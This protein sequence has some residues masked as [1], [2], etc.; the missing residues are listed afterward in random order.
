MHLIHES[1]RG[2]FASKNERVLALPLEMDD[3]SEPTSA[4][5][6]CWSGPQ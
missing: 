3:R 6:V 2:S 1:A 4:R 5:S